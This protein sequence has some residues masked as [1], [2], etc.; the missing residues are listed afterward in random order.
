M[1][2]IQPILLIGLPLALLPIIIHLINQH[3]HRTVN[4]AAMMFLLDAKKLTKGIARLRQILIL[5]LRV[6]A[7]LFLL[8]AASRPLA[9]GWLALTGGKPDTV[10]VLLDR[11]SSM[12]QQILETGES[13]RSAAVSKLSDLLEKTAK[14]SNLIL[15]DSANLEPIQIIDP[16]A[17]A[18]L[19]QASPT[20]SAASI[21]L[22]LQRAIDYLE[23]D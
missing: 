15:I 20:A 8:F 7:V 2:F 11:S 5:S 14:N 1:S 16:L 13:K 4:W 3:R 22:L 23:T 10:I 19:P 6:L 18:T 9:G 12:E 21:P 17:I